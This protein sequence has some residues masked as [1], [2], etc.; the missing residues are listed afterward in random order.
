MKPLEKYKINNNLANPKKQNNNQNSNNALYEKNRPFNYAK[1]TNPQKKNINSVQKN[2]N[3]QNKNFSD[4]NPIVTTPK[5]PINN[6]INNSLTNAK[7]REEEKEEF[8]RTQ[9]YINYLKE[10][11]NSSYYANNE[12]NSK[13]SLLIEKSKSLNEEIKNNN[14]LYEKLTKS[15]NEK[16]KLNNEY[17]K[18]YENLIKLQKAKNNENKD[19][20]LKLEEK[21]KE[22]QTKIQIKKKEN[23]SKEEI[24]S[25]LKNTLEILEKNKSS[26]NT[27][28][29]IKELK[30]EKNLISNLKLNIEKITKDLYTKNI[31]LEEKKKNM[32]FLINNKSNKNNNNIDNQS[33]KILNAE[34][35]KIQNVIA[36]Q[37]LLINKI[38]DNQKEIRD[39][40]EEQKMIN[41]KSIKGDKKYKQLLIEEKLKNKE[42]LMNL[43]N[44]NKEAKELTLVHNQIKIKYEGE[45]NKI[46]DEIEK[47]LKNRKLE[48]KNKK[49]NVDYSAA[50]NQLLEEQKNLKMF[51]R[52]FKEKLLIKN[53]IEE[54]IALMQKENQK[55]KNLLN[56]SE[57]NR[58][59]ILK[60]NASKNNE[61]DNKKDSNNSE[62][63]EEKEENEENEEKEN[64]IEDQIKINLNSIPTNKNSCIYTITDKGQLFTY[65]IIQKKF[66][67]I[68]V[69]SIKGWEDFIKIYLSNYEGSLLLNTLEGLYILTGDIF[70][71]LYYYSSKLNSISKIISFNHSHKFGGLILSPDHSQLLA[72]GGCDTNEVEI[73]NLEENTID[74]LPDLLTERINSSYSFIGKNLV[75][76]F[77]GQ[78]NNSIEYIDLDEEDK[79]WKNVEY[80]NSTVENIYGHI[81]VPINENEILIV[82]GKNND[83]MIMFNFKEKILEITDNKI[84]FLDTVGEYLFDKDKNY[85]TI[86]NL[87]KKDKNKNEITQVICMDSNG[88]IH[89]LDND[90]TYIVLLVDIHELE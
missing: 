15:I 9:K 88:N 78:N 3:F 89:L 16:I 66:T 55:L 49:D 57:N 46:K 37:K 5:P 34:I 79:E 87:D 31:K 76:C 84:P 20:N 64:K 13:N 83:K 60:S 29:K 12:I 70:T 67:T 24:I 44:S 11:L 74:N 59:N 18:N 51:N 61:L 40:I 43:I 39:K 80:T 35:D 63:N 75:Y 45:I 28:D 38:K 42:L 19:K 36:N 1:D 52:E 21:I 85:N 25:N 4:F 56:N 86:I 41:N 65:N 30:E 33:K 48:N 10:H 53:A 50:I 26:Q 58:N 22:L 32:I 2:N 17:K 68:D 7:E 69:H 71:D 54:K 77:F 23:K 62:S 6:F 14:L 82:G 8:E 81:S 90:S 73:L 72:L 27:K 47:L